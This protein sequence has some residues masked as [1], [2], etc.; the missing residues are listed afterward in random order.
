M[1]KSMLS[2]CAPFPELTANR[3]WTEYYWA[4]HFAIGRVADWSLM[5]VSTSCIE[6]NGV[7]G[8][9]AWHIDREFAEKIIN[10]N[11]QMISR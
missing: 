11:R 7:R 5:A 1:A 6:V 3:L 2:F 10:N 8:Y 4:Q 9:A